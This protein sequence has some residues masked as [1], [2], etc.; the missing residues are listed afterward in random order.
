MEIDLSTAKEANY[1]HAR[2][3]AI[4]PEATDEM[5]ASPDLKDA[6]DARLPSLL[7]DFAATMESLGFTY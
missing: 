2:S 6:L 3:N 4:W 7:A 5:L 1:D